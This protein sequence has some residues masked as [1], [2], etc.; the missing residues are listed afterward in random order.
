MSV[1]GGYTRH[2]AARFAQ[3]VGR[4]AGS[5]ALLWADGAVSYGELDRLSNQVARQL[6]D[7]GVR[8]RQPVAIAIDKCTFA[9]AA[10]LGCLKVGAPY[11][12]VDPASPQVRA[13]AIVRQCQPRFAFAGA[14]LAAVF[15]C[16]VQTIPPGGSEDPPLRPSIPDGPIEL[17]WHID[18]SDP[19]YVMFTSCS[20]GVPKGA[21]ISHANLMELIR[22]APWQYG[23]GP[24]EVVTNVNPLFFDNSVFDIYS[25]LFSGAAL[26]PITGAQL[27]DPG[28]VLSLFDRLGCTVYFSVPSL[29][30]YLQRLKLITPQSFRTLKRIIF[31]GEGYPIP[32][33]RQLFSDVGDRI[34]LHNVYGPTECTCI[35][36][37]YR[38]TAADL[39]QSTLYP[40]L[41]T[42]IP[43]FSELIADESGTPVQAG[44]SGE[45]YLGGPAVG[46]GYYGA[47]E[48]SATAFVQ[49]PTHERFA[50]RMYRTGDLVRR[51]EDGKLHF[52]GR[53]DMQIKL[54]GYRIE[55][56]EIE[57]ALQAVEGVTEAVAVF[58][59]DGVIGRIVGVVAMATPLPPA[60]IRRAV[61]QRL[62]KYMVPERVR[63]VSEL[64]KNANGK[65]DRKSLRA[66]VERGEL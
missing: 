31:G 53:S 37:S 35:C 65:V 21:T 4:Q 3:V 41:G 28:A 9:Y 30:I 13:E 48:Q 40:P 12:V 8:K 47:P 59:S 24:G 14:E 36:S 15:D 19:A 2:A 22:W 39:D 25:S 66:A 63:V 44:E 5:P 45:L 46:L 62:P 54:Q 16:P 49:N 34:E 42:L 27:K 43:H 18:G 26:A 50:D 32:M 57:H 11:F 33:L 58:S 60:A 23:I 51:A 52:V 20:T 1:T 38:I 10:I 55:L 29:L 6:L 61:E 64:P 17:P 7:S 56:G